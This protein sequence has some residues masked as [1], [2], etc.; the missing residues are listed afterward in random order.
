MKIFIIILLA[1]LWTCSVILTC[2]RMFTPPVKGYIIV[3][4]DEE[5]NAAYFFLDPIN[6]SELEKQLA[7]GEL[8]YVTFRV[9]KKK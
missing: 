8:D 6:K 5:E 1:I 2:K 4:I 7:A 3:T 9:R